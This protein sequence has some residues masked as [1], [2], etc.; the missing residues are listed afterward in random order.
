[1]WAT[2]DASRSHMYLRLPPG[3]TLPSGAAG[4]R[5]CGFSKGRNRPSVDSQPNVGR[6]RI[7]VTRLEHGYRGPGWPERY[8]CEWS[9]VIGDRV[10]R[11]RRERDLTLIQLAGMIH[12]PGDDDPYS[13]GY[14]SRLER[15]SSRP[16]LYAYLAI[17]AALG[18]SPGRL[19]GPDDVEKDV[20][21]AEMTLIRL[22]RRLQV[23][24]E[25]AIARI[26]G[27]AGSPADAQRG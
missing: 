19:L 21:E 12:K 20:S 16:Q 9:I 3:A 27:P 7:N 18:V 4:S 23:P 11:L 24:V 15:G 25:E 8:R 22:V 26:V 2:Q 17:A 14:F 6:D 1:M 5:R 13:I 10:R